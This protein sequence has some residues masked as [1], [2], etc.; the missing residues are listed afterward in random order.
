[1]KLKNLLLTFASVFFI[2]NMNAQLNVNT[3]GKVIINSGSSETRNAQELIYRIGAKWYYH[4]E[5]PLWYVD[6]PQNDMNKAQ[7]NIGC[8]IYEVKSLDNTSGAYTVERTMK[9]SKGAVIS[10]DNILVSVRG[11]KVFMKAGG[12]ENLVHDPSLNV[13]EEVPLSVDIKEGTNKYKAVLRFNGSQQKENE[14][15]YRY[16]ILIKSIDDGMTFTKYGYDFSSICGV[17][18]LGF[19]PGYKV[20]TITVRSSDQETEYYNKYEHFLRAYVKPDGEAVLTNF[21]KKSEFYKNGESYDFCYHRPTSVNPI[22]R[23]EPL[24]VDYAA[25]RITSSNAWIYLYSTN[26]LLV[27]TKYESMEL[28]NIKEGCY[29]AVSRDA[30][31]RII[32]IKKISL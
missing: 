1:M 10:T 31:F 32:G 8:A 18:D 5:D 19:Y 25:K 15:L 12:K 17:L 13:G 9:D 22:D 6:P 23:H 29:I 3:F 27:S 28:G 20:F 30:D 21:W 7:R 24:Q 11:N 14:I 2:I 26:G 16:E 4:I